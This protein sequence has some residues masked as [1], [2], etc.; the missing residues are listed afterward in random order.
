MN[1]PSINTACP[2]CGSTNAA[3]YAVL[4]NAYI[5]SHALNKEIFS[6]RRLPDRIHYQLVKCRNDQLVRSSPTFPPSVAIALYRK[7]EVTYQNEV[8]NL[9]KSYIGCL[10]P[11]LQKL[12]KNA[13][14]LEIGC[15]SGFLL[16]ALRKRG[17]LNVTGIE[18]STAATQLSDTDVRDRIITEP[19]SKNVI[20]GKKFDLICMFQ[21][22]DHLPDLAQ[23]MEDCY[24]SLQP[25]GYLI[26]LHH[27]VEY[28][29]RKLLGERHPI[30]DIEHLQL[31][32]QRTSTLLF[33]KHGFLTDSVRSPQ[34]IVSLSHLIWL[35]PIPAKLKKISTR[36][37]KTLPWLNITFH[38]KL[39]NVAIIG[40]KPSLAHVS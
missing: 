14:I 30:I 11:V 29:L 1:L 9:I 17:F 39:G 23:C 15:G 37:T 10:E 21:T 2:L 36:I 34:S 40:K 6:A 18:P 35:L 3:D 31:F 22:L 16:A 27:D 33:E 19:F 13:Q 24:A 32:S 26:S 38:L 8:S 4:Y 5:P 25:G 20:K 7:S 12:S 28:H